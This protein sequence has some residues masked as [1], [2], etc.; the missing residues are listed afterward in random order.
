MSVHFI[1]DD[2]FLEV[3]PYHDGAL[4]EIGDKEADIDKEEIERLIEVL[5]NIVS[6]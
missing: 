5:K 1:S 2:G 3:S 4:I 6:P